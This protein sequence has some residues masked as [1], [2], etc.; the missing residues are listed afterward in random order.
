[1][2]IGVPTGPRC[3]LLPAA[4]WRPP[5]YTG[6]LQERWSLRYKQRG[7]AIAGLWL[8]AQFCRNR[9]GWIPQMGST[10]A[11]CGP[12]R[13]ATEG[14]SIASLGHAYQSASWHSSRAFPSRQVFATAMTH[15]GIT[16]VLATVNQQRGFASV[17]LWL[18][19]RALANAFAG[20]N[21][22]SPDR[23]FLSGQF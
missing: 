2:P 10:I 3:G 4:N 20:R 21:F 9:D 23:V 14:T 7:F 12:L 1:M 18:N 13:G 11:S 5:R 15:R 17:G 19:S 22:W 6:S 8:M 16:R